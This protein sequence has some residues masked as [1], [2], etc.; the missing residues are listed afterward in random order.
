MPHGDLENSRRL[1]ARWG[2]LRPDDLDYYAADGLVSAR[3]L[4]TG[5]EIRVDPLLGQL[6][7]PDPSEIDE[8]L[9]RRSQEVH[10]LRREVLRLRARSGEPWQGV[11]AEPPA[12]R[13]A[14]VV[15]AVAHQ[16]DL[17]ATLDAL[18]Q[19]S[20]SLDDFDVVVVDLEH[21]LLP[22]VRGGPRPPA[23]PAGPWA[24]TRRAV[25]PRA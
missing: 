14:T 22:T 1:T 21:K 20:A 23:A 25:E 5:V 8:L 12:P 15:I 6:A 9:T 7:V 2:R 3:H 11:L 19:Q 13:S 10:D 18:E 16:P 4:A 17:V 24:R